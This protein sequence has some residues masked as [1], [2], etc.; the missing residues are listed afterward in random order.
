VTL[1]RARPAAS[2]CAEGY[3]GR[4]R[5]THIFLCGPSQAVRNLFRLSGLLEALECCCDSPTEVK[6]KLQEKAEA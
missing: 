5:G 2:G 3:V 4:R 1:E 6:R